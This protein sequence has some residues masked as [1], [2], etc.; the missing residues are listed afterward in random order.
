MVAMAANKA[1]PSSLLCDILPGLYVIL[2]QVI[3]AS[4]HVALHCALSQQSETHSA[5]NQ[6]DG[7]PPRTPLGKALQLD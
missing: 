4:A 2:P 1:A 5:G 7:Q 6:A 3:L